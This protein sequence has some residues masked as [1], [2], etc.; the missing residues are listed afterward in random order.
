VNA[1]ILFRNRRTTDSDEE[2]TYVAEH[3]P[4]TTNRW[5]P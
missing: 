3:L 5:R 2:Q 4:L 1:I